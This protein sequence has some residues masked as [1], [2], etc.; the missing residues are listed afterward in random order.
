M[1]ITLKEKCLSQWKVAHDSRTFFIFSKSAPL[2]IISKTIDNCIILSTFILKMFC[3]TARTKS[4][5]HNIS[6]EI[7]LFP[8]T[9]PRCRIFCTISRTEAGS[10][11]C[12]V[13]L[14]FSS[15]RYCRL[16]VAQPLQFS[17]RP[18]GH[19]SAKTHRQQYFCKACSPR[20]N[21]L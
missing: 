9:W 3:K 4:V 1:F 17:V 16:W 10:A 2:V 18:A 6:A 14:D 15:F 13:F 11:L 12:R 19:Q 8:L 20:I 5:M 21:S 7:L